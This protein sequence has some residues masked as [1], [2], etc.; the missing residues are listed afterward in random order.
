MLIITSAAPSCVSWT[1]VFANEVIKRLCSKTKCHFQLTSLTSIFNI[2]QFHQLLHFSRS[3]LMPQQI[4]ERQLHFSAEPLV[5]LNL[6]SAG[7][8]KLYMQQ[9]KKVLTQEIL[10][11]HNSELFFFPH[12]CRKRI[13]YSSLTLGQYG[14]LCQHHVGLST[15]WQGWSFIVKHPLVEKTL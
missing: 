2:F 13:E 15:T 10:I 6:K 8:G 3:P 9:K 1:H 14:Q 11:L 12:S 7:L 5:L 4:G